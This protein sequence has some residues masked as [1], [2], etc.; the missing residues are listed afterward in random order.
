MTRLLENTT[1][2]LFE[3]LAPGEYVI[4]GLHLRNVTLL[5]PALMVLNGTVSLRGETRFRNE[6]KEILWE[7]PE[8]QDIV[9][10]AIG[11]VNP[12]FE[13][14]II[15]GVGIAAKHDAITA[16]LG[17]TVIGQSGDDC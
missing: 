10:G 17:R 15:E 8:E 14:C 1:V 2:R 4:E 12:I 5:G 7:I 9:V 3:L 11:L 13:D 6:L 16:L